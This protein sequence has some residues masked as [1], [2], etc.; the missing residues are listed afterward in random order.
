M[1]HNILTLID[2]AR[3]WADSLVLSIGFDLHLF[4]IAGSAY[5][6]S[7]YNPLPP[8]TPSP[9]LRDSPRKGG[10]GAGAG[11]KEKQPA[12]EL[13]VSVSHRPTPRS[14]P[15]HLQRSLSYNY[16]LIFSSLGG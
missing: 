5:E 2:I 11:A 4:T 15:V 16:V 9:S 13:T 3:I 12:P 1:V 8:R 10:K 14:T 7:P 6:P